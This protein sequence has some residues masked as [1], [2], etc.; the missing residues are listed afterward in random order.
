MNHLFVIDCNTQDDS[1]KFLVVDV[2]LEIESNENIL[3]QTTSFCT[4][5]QRFTRRIQTSVQCGAHT[6][7]ISPDNI[8]SK[9]QSLS[10]FKEQHVVVNSSSRARRRWIAFKSTANVGSRGARGLNSPPFFIY[11]TNHLSNIG[12]CPFQI[13]LQFASG[14]GCYTYS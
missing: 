2:R 4:I 9:I 10:N 7:C 12:R 5:L 8:T 1:I 11:P 13:R 3:P 6:T 14:G